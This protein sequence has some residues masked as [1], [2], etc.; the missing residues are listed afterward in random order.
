MTAIQIRVEMA[1]PATT[2]LLGTNAHVQR[3]SLEPT[4]KHVKIIMVSFQP[5][6]YL[7]VFE[8]TVSEAHAFGTFAPCMFERQS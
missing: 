8:T 2:W 5:V 3:D 6:E 1:P 4:V 7:V